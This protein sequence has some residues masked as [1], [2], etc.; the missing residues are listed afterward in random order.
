MHDKARKTDSKGNTS[1]TENVWHE[2][3]DITMI[4]HNGMSA[5]YSSDV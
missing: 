5:I 3:K 1:S 4:V 2:K